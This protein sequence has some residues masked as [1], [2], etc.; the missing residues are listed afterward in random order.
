MKMCY[1]LDSYYGTSRSGLVYEILRLADDTYEIRPS[2][3]RKRR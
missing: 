1:L 3:S 2:E